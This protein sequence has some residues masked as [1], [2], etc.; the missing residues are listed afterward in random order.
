MS[1]K[2]DV[3]DECMSLSC[4]ASCAASQIYDLIKD[5]GMGKL[6]ADN[7]LHLMIEEYRRLNDISDR[8]DKLADEL[9]KGENND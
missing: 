8:L 3:V 5:V 1:N 9:A 6:T 4:M 2:I 7:A